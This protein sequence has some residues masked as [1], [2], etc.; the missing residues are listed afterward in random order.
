MIGEAIEELLDLSVTELGIGAAL[1]AS[2]EDT[3]GSSCSCS[4]SLCCS[5]T[6]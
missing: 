2:T 1:Y 5:C 6:I 3:G 4:W